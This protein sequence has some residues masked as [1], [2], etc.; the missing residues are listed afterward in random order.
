MGT[1]KCS[2]SSKRIRFLTSK[3]TPKGRIGIEKTLN[4]KAIRDYRAA[5]FADLQS[6]IAGKHSTV[7]WSETD[8]GF[9]NG[10]R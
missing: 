6:K 9:R 2:S 8:E 10:C 5:A 4:S 3:K 1:G 7:T